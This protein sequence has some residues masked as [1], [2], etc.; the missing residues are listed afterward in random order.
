M[1]VSTII[2]APAVFLLAGCVATELRVTNRAGTGIHIYSGHTK[3]VTTI[4]AGAAGTAPHTSGRII[5]ITQRDE[6]WEYDNVQSFVDEATRSCKRVSLHVDIQ[7]D[8]SIALPSGKKLTP[9]LR[10][11]Q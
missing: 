10:F 9:T 7:P 1:R 6:V 5:V 2:L 8:G 3:K 11:G 4:S